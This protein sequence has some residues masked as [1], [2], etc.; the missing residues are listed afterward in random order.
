MVAIAQL[1]PQ[2]VADP[3]RIV[4]GVR[5]LDMFYIYVLKSL[6]SG[7]KYVGL[8][9]A[10]PEERLKQHNSGNSEWSRAHRPF[11]LVHT[12]I[13]YD[14]V[15]ARKRELFLKTG[16]GRKALENLIKK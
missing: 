3:P 5:V 1:P 6:N 12:E 10:S 2:I 11:K 4:A 13:F 7:K 16:Q 15:S 9:A 8:T 14:K